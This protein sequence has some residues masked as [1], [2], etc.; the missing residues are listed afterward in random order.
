MN[1][2][3]KGIDK[4]DT[5]K[6]TTADGDG[7]GSQEVPSEAAGQPLPQGVN[8]GGIEKR[9]RQGESAVWGGRGAPDGS[10]AHGSHSSSRGGG[11]GDWWETGTRYAFQPR[12]SADQATVLSLVGADSRR[13]G[14]VDFDRGGVSRPRGGGSV[15]GSQMGDGVATGSSP[16][17]QGRQPNEGQNSSREL[18][19]I[20]RTPESHP[21]HGKR[22][23]FVA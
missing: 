11:S 4:K 23:F 13:D 3:K 8:L 2:R 17:Q 16:S 12:L 10:S 20:V 6:S 18:M 14:G 19:R 1:R 22:V 15:G 9:L 21:D 7:A 5:S